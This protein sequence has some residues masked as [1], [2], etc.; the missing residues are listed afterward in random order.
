MIKLKNNKGFT[1]IE[2]IMSI[3]ILSIV[4]AVVLQLFVSSKGL[5]TKSRAIDIAGIYAANA[6]EQTKSLTKK[7]ISIIA[8]IKEEYYD[9]NWNKTNNLEKSRY[10]LSLIV[11]EKTEGLFRIQ[12]MVTDIKENNELVEYNTSYYAHIKE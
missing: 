3:A 5:N 8:G 2:V 4:S 9:E 11:D 10:K 6:I 12:S 1:L 7:E